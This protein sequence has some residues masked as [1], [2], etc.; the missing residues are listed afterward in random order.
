MF[1]NIDMKDMWIM[2]KNNEKMIEGREVLVALEIV[3]HIIMHTAEIWESII[4]MP[5]DRSITE[6]WKQI[7][8]GNKTDYGKKK[9]LSDFKPGSIRIN[10]AIFFQF[11]IFS[12]TH[13]MEF[14]RFYACTETAQCLIMQFFK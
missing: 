5:A 6:Y 4:C 3:Y 14:E 11:H 8:T 9:N 1:L 13:F 10:F 2:S 7:F 12:H